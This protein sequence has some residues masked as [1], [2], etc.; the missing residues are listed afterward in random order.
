MEIPSQYPEVNP[1]KQRRNIYFT[2][3]YRNILAADF[4]DEDEF[5]E[6][7]DVIKE[8]LPVTFRVNPTYPCYKKIIDLF[9]NEERLR[10]YFFKGVEE[11]SEVEVEEFKRRYGTDLNNINLSK[12]DWYPSKL[13]YSL[14]AS[15]AGFRK[16]KGLKLFHK[17]IQ[18][19]GEA[20]L[21]S[22]QE[23]VSMI[24]PYLLEVE[25]GDLVLDVCAAPGS[26]TGQIMELIHQKEAAEKISIPRGGV[27]ANE[28]NIQRANRLT[29][30]VKRITT[31]GIAVINHEGQS[32][33][34]VINKDGAEIRFDRV[35]VDVPCSGDGAIR[36]LPQRWK[37]WSS[38]D[39][40]NLHPLQIE[41][42]IRSI[43]LTKVGGRI[44][45][46]T[47]SLSPIE[48]EAVVAEVFRRA[49]QLAP[50]AIKLV[51]VHE[52]LPNFKGRKGLLHWINA[53]KVKNGPGYQ[54]EG[55]FKFEDLFTVYKE[56]NDTVVKESN[57]NLSKSMF[58][59]TEEELRGFGI[60]NTMRV[61]PHDQNTGGFYL[62]IIDKIA[63]VPFPQ[64]ISKNNIATENDMSNEIEE[65]VKI[66]ETMKEELDNI[67]EYYGLSPVIRLIIHRKLPRIYLCI[68]QEK[69]ESTLRL[70]E[71]LSIILRNLLRI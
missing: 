47:C 50:G 37:K 55:N 69:K 54:D 2:T 29:H 30:Q 11:S 5:G 33:P 28:L 38:V 9:D 31:G 52:K 58:P 23:V 40:M 65:F 15:R 56:W 48:N 59:T 10:E 32:I 14:N 70:I 71:L 7:E 8:Q 24:P 67:T 44:V 62:A 27:V 16:N 36:K 53:I 18:N 4:K 25:A 19:A 39:G 1:M 60:E 34:K 20:G 22:R 68:K 46:S 63:E 51:N 3:Y 6:F 64:S 42:L 21:L 57:G 17:T 41:L 26:K 61:M 66:E 12:V 13:I 49:E 45:Y 43:Q 35:L